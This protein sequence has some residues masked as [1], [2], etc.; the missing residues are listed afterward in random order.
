MIAEQQNWA[1]TGSECKGLLPL[2]SLWHLDH[3]IP[4]FQ[5]GTNLPENLQV[6]CSTCHNIKTQR[7][8]V[9]FFF[10]KR[11]K[12]LNFTTP[13]ELVTADQSLRDKIR[14]LEAKLESRTV[15]TIENRT[16]AP[17]CPVYLHKDA[18]QQRWRVMLPRSRPGIKSKY[19]SNIRHGSVESAKKALVDW[20]EQNNIV[21]RFV[22]E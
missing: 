15:L 8:R 9:D 16:D 22:L 2:S 18:H 11:L 20:C 7:E 13:C 10:E 17:I 3:I 5:G 4:L 19:F 21:P 14:E 6:L 12:A 1:C